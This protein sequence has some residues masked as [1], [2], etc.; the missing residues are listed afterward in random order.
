MESIM[1]PVLAFLEWY[2]WIMVAALVGLIIF[3]VQY[4][5]RNM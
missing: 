3:Y 4:K 5:K 1:T 2:Q